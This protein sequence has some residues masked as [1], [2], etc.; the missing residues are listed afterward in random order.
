MAVSTDSEN[1]LD[2]KETR[3]ETKENEVFPGS[4]YGDSQCAPANKII[5]K[6]NF[7]PPDSHSTPSFSHKVVRNLDDSLF[8]FNRLESPLPYSPLSSISSRGR[9][10]PSRSLKATSFSAK[11]LKGKRK[12]EQIFDFPQEERKGKKKKTKQE[13]FVIS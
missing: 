11:T 1:D 2:L 10:S 4:T 6:E 5:D 13:V 12:S 7:T 3:A 8:G 9:P